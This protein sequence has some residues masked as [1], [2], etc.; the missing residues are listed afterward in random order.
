[1][2]LEDVDL[3]STNLLWCDQVRPLYITVNDVDEALHRC[4]TFGKVSINTIMCQHDHVCGTRHEVYASP[5]S[6]TIR[7]AS[8]EMRVTSV[9]ASTLRAEFRFETSV[10]EY[11]QRVRS[12]SSLSRTTCSEVASSEAARTRRKQCGRQRY[13]SHVAKPSGDRRRRK[14][15]SQRIARE[16]PLT[17]L[18][19]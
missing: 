1:M 16:G 5:S 14:S 3:C 18:T 4:S 7:L 2:T 11:K 19:I 8:H 17:G 13:A 12:I 10:G 9:S 15:G 6:S